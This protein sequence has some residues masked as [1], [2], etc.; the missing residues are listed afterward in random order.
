MSNDKE[1]LW[2]DLVGALQQGPK[3]PQWVIRD[4]H[5]HNWSMQ[6]YK[7]NIEVGYVLIFLYKVDNSWIPNPGNP[8]TNAHVG[9]R[10]RLDVSVLE[11]VEERVLCINCKKHIFHLEPFNGS[12]ASLPA[13]EKEEI[14]QVMASG[15]SKKAINFVLETLEDIN[16]T[17]AIE[18]EASKKHKRKKAEK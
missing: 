1:V 16:R 11:G 15:I 12:I 2:T 6:I 18:L 3:G 8:I 10:N 5:L 13:R 4:S 14:E 7:R 17:E 9:A